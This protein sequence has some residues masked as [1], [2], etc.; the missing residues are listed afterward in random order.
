MP[1]R[2]N[3]PVRVAAAAA[4]PPRAA[5]DGGAISQITSGGQIEAR[6]ATA[7]GSPCA[8]VGVGHGGS[9]PGAEA[10]GSAVAAGNRPAIVKRG[11]LQICGQ[12]ACP[13]LA[14]G[15]AETARCPVAEHRREAAGVRPAGPLA[16]GQ[17][18]LV[19]DR[20][21]ERADE[22]GACVI[23]DHA[24]VHQIAGHRRCRAHRDVKRAA[25]LHGLGAVETPGA[26]AI[27]V[28]GSEPLEVTGDRAAQGSS[29]AQAGDGARSVGQGQGPAATDNLAAEARPRLGDQ[30][31]AGGA[32]Q[33]RL[34]VR[35]DDH[36]EV[37]HGEVAAGFLDDSGVAADGSSG[38]I[39]ESSAGVD[40][41]AVAPAPVRETALTVPAAAPVDVAR[42]CQKGAIQEHYPGGAPAGGAVGAVAAEAI[43]AGRSVGAAA[44]AQTALAAGDFATI[45]EAAAIHPGALAA[46]ASLAAD[47]AKADI[48]GGAASHPTDPTDPADDRT[49]VDGRA[50]AH[51]HADAA[52]AALGAPAPVRDV[53]PGPCRNGRPD[54]A[55]ASLAAG[56]PAVVGQS[57]HVQVGPDAA[58]DAVVASVAC[59][60]A[61][62]V[63]AVAGAV[64]PSGG[65]P[66]EDRS[67]AD[68][69]RAEASGQASRPDRSVESDGQIV[70]G[71][72]RIAR[73]VGDDGVHAHA[74]SPRAHSN[75]RR[76]SK[77]API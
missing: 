62:I 27:E 45:G 41:D 44:T 15:G 57:R 26:A 48:A 12:T 23:A 51:G 29:A 5:D 74:K 11:P 33:H 76:A 64:R 75:L 4:G 69:G 63:G 9:H 43:G 18:S 56:N 60:G 38:L 46:V 55:G 10:T 34:T 8:A 35:R 67:L 77:A 14:A 61:V 36:A 52:L 71:V 30:H 20:R 32:E 16:V 50:T 28:V 73:H 17:G 2:A 47:P 40:M 22:A 3:R 42:I 1:P 21:T 59:V 49:V 13:A 39:D 58:A 19:V 72:E 66:R 54:A 31:V 6:A 25:R 53:V 70:A 37:R 68:D 65:R 24:V 7:A